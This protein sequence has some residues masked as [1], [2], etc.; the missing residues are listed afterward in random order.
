MIPLKKRM[1]AFLLVPLA[2]SMVSCTGLAPLATTALKLG[3][4]KLAFSCLP[5]GTK[6]DTPNGPKAVESIRPGD[7]VIGFGGDPVKVLQKHSYAEDPKPLRFHRVA[8]T[9]GSVVDLCDMHR[10]GGR[11]ARSLTPGKKLGDLTVESV[12][13]Y[14]GVLR[15]YDLLTEDEGYQIDGVPVNSMIGEMAEAMK[16]GTLSAN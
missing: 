7:Q 11:R 6:V 8:F 16:S 9:N 12:T 1:A 13:T 4:M 5:E 14:G 2:L 3:M 15:S 10:V